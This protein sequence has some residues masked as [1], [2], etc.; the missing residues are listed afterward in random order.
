M[1]FAIR[2]VTKAYLLHS[3]HLSS[4]DTLYKLRRKLIQ[5]KEIEK[6]V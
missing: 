2:R 4:L 5:I 1:N 3:A 6:Y